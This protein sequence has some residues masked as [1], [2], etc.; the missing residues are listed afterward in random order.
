MIVKIDNFQK[1]NFYNEELTFFE[2][3]IYIPL[4]PFE[5][6]REDFEIIKDRI[7][8][9]SFPQTK[10][11][12]F[13]E[14]GNVKGGAVSDY[15]KD[16]SVVHHIYIAVKPEFQKHGIGKQ[17][18]NKVQDDAIAEGYKWIVLEADN[19][20]IT[21]DNQTSMNPTS[22]LNMYLKWGFKI[23]PYQHVQ[24]PLDENKDYDYHLLLL[25]KNLTDESFNEKH[26]TNFV[27]DFF[28]EYNGNEKI[29]QET[30]KTIRFSI[31]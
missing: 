11:Y 5:N 10:I 9:D 15:F 21:N 26:L 25:Y 31:T 23:T 18:I 4:F 7:K 16:S 20:D 28:K 29:L 1:L 6:E 13:I 27:K 17:L 12:L 19:P 22:R 8:Y 2:K 24:P 14:D 30:L 3:H